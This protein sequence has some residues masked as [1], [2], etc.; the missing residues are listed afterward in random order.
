MPHRL[1][2]EDAFQSPE[3][4][5]YQVS[6]KVLLDHLFCR[7]GVLCGDDHVQ[8]I[9]LLTLFYH[10]VSPL[11]FKVLQSP[12]YILMLLALSVTILVAIGIYAIDKKILNHYI[13][14]QVI[15]V[16]LIFVGEILLMILF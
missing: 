4:L 13:I 6:L 9:V 1:Y 16:F 14:T 2:G 15:L 11:G 8:A 7:E 12:E 10:V 5:L 3:S